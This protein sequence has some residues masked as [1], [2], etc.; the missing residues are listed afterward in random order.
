MGIL[1]IQVLIGGI[2]YKNYNVVDMFNI[3]SLNIDSVLLNNS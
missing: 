3:L 2:K 1:D